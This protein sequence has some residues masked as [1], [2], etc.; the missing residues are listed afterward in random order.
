[1]ARN[2]TSEMRKKLVLLIFNTRMR[3]GT[4][5]G[6]C[7]SGCGFLVEE[8]LLTRGDNGPSPAG[9]LTPLRC[10]GVYTLGDIVAVSRPLKSQ[11]FMILCSD[12][13][14]VYHEH[15]ELKKEIYIFFHE[16]FQTWKSF[17]FFSSDK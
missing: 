7:V 4:L 11:S 15:L 16:K 13:V 2:S 8:G 1:M 14:S 6:L 17:S 10:V 5:A 9:S 3:P 12:L